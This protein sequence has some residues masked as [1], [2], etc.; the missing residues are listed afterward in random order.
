[1][2]QSVF[3]I[4]LFVACNSVFAQK[5]IIERENF[6]IISEIINTNL[7][8]PTELFPDFYQNQ[9][10]KYPF[11]TSENVLSPDKST[12]SIEETLFAVEMKFGKEEYTEIP[13]S[14]R[15][16]TYNENGILEE[17]KTENKKSIIF[18]F[19]GFGETI[20]KFF[21]YEKND[22]GIFS[23][24]HYDKNGEMSSRS[25]IKYNEKGQIIK[26]EFYLK[27]Y[28]IINKSIVYEYN[29]DEKRVKTT[30]Y[31]NFYDTVVDVVPRRQLLNNYKP[32]FKVQRGFRNTFAIGAYELADFTTSDGFDIRNKTKQEVL[33]DINKKWIETPI[34]YVRRDYLNNLSDKWEI[35]IVFETL[36]NKTS[37]MKKLFILK[38]KYFSKEKT[39]VENKITKGRENIEKNLKTLYNGQNFGY[40]QRKEEFENLGVKL[41][42]FSW[43]FQNT[44]SSGFPINYP[45]T[46][47]IVKFYKNSVR[48]L[49]TENLKTLENENLSYSELET[50]FS[51]IQN[52]FTDIVTL[53][54]DKIKDRKKMMELEK[55]NSRIEKLYVENPLSSY[56]SYK[57]KHLY[58]AYLKI[59]EIVISKKNFEAVSLEEILKLQDKMINLSSQNTRDL[60]RKLK[61]EENIIVIINTIIA[62]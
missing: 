20:S 17:V 34:F 60:E 59:Q 4:L 32:D 13:N 26:C 43:W 11:I 21:K 38:R 30:H 14:K 25:L 61:K 10:F 15:T 31:D 51:K 50:L 41:D 7:S 53:T 44:N 12:F 1:M 58:L 57:K 9:Y 19:G 40:I 28:K 45:F 18:D 29:E 56:R 42:K 33:D 49:A 46:K 16:L 54:L 3:I 27:D 48:Q 39:E 5:S 6:K 23:I 36:Y 8:N 55:N 52:D 47:E 24:I 2:K 35:E 37:E 62:E 22:F